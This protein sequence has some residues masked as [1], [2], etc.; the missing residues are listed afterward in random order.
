M[1][2]NCLELVTSR[3]RRSPHRPDLSPI[4][5]LLKKVPRGVF[6]NTLFLD[7]NFFP[8]DTAQLKNLGNNFCIMEKYAIVVFLYGHVAQWIEH[9]IPVLRV[10]GS[11]PSVLVKKRKKSTTCFPEGAGRFSWGRFSFWLKGT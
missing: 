3:V 2:R 9:Q 6:E 7:S 5:C 1:A 10:G 4:R 8:R 11:N